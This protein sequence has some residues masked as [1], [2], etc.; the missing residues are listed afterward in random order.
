MSNLEITKE[1]MMEHLNRYF[2]DEVESCPLN[3]IA[4]VDVL[5]SKYQPES[6]K[7]EALKYKCPDCG[8]VLKYDS[9]YFIGPNW[10][11]SND[12]RFTTEQI[13]LRCGALI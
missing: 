8:D 4:C 12:N 6:I 1:Q 10:I 3:A 9:K 7:R 2:T 13:I 5:F 11:C